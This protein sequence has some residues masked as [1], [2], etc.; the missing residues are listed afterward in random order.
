MSRS[1]AAL[2]EVRKQA[3]ILFIMTYHKTSKIPLEIIE[4]PILFGKRENRRA[5]LCPSVTEG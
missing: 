3:V 4:M 1:Y 2:Q 5:W